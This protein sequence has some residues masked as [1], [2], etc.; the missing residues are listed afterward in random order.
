VNLSTSILR[1][2]VMPVLLFVAPLL[3]ALLLFGNRVSISAFEL[4]S[5]RPIQGKS[6]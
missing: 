4:R 1:E 6:D 2:A 3:F 5:G